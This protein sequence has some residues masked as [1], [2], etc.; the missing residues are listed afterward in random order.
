MKS[1][2]EHWNPHC[3]Y[4]SDNLFVDVTLLVAQINRKFQKQSLGNVQKP[5]H[6]PLLKPL[7][8]TFQRWQ[9]NNNCCTYSTEQYTLS[10]G[11]WRCVL[12]LRKEQ[13][14]GRDFCSASELCV[15]QSG[16]ILQ[17][18]WVEQFKWWQSLPLDRSLRS[19]PR[20]PA[21]SLPERHSHAQLQRW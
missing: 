16:L 10:L 18:H 4:V 2:C 19:A 17:C 6:I 21:Q 7:C 8:N 13:T 14:K 12:V 20:C 11:L 9:L 1:I 15:K 5:L 3:I